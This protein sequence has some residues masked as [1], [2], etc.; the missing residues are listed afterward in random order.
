MSYFSI[1]K[2]RVKIKILKSILNSGTS[3]LSFE[4]AKE[5]I[6]KYSKAPCRQPLHQ[7]GNQVVHKP[8]FFRK[9]DGPKRN[10]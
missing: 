9:E 1:L 10:K 5:L 2:I 3:M 7:I 6:S 4:R 8:W